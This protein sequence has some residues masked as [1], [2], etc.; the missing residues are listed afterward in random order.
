MCLSSRYRRRI[1]YVFVFPSFG[2]QICGSFRPVDRIFALTLRPVLSKF[3]FSSIQ[4]L[5]RDEL[6][7]DTIGLLPV[8]VAK[9]PEITRIG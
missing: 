5:Q 4:L 7:N 8:T 6:A 9:P 1:S 3:A 2:R